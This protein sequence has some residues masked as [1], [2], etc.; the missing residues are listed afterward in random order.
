MLHYLQKYYM[1]YLTIFTYNIT[2]LIVFMV[3]IT[4][5][6]LLSTLLEGVEVYR[7]NICTKFL[8]IFSDEV[9]FAC[10]PCSYF[11]PV[12]CDVASLGKWFPMFSR[13]LSPSYSRVALYMQTDLP[14]C[15]WFLYRLHLAQHLLNI[16]LHDPELS[17]GS[18]LRHT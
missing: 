11:L 14:F 17:M 13:K 3:I 10:W 4:V 5:C 1:L 15:A 12:G 7:F 18:A 8:L 9:C 6:Y 2:F 16:S